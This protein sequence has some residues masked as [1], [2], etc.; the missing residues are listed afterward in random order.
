VTKREIKHTDAIEKLI[1]QKIDWLSGDLNALPPSEEGN[2]YERP[3]RG[4]SRDKDRDRSRGRGRGAPVHKS[5]ID[6]P[7]TRVEQP[8]AAPAPLATPAPAKVDT[9]RDERKF[10]NSRSDSN[11]SHDNGSSHNGSSNNARPISTANDDNR[12]SPSRYHRDQDDGPTPVGFGEDIPA[13]MLIVASAGA[14]G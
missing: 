11:R 3:R 2:D 13:F 14:K 9:M 1:G 7:D 8:M 6:A 5:D 4:S 10:E 12:E